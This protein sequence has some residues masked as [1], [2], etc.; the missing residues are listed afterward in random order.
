[1]KWLLITVNVSP[2]AVNEWAIGGRS[3]PKTGSSETSVPPTG[4]TEAVLKMIPTLM[5]L[6]DSSPPG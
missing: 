2:K 6:V 1:M 3:A 4:V 5:A